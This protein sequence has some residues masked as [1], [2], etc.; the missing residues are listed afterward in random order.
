MIERVGGGRREE[1]REGD[2]QRNRGVKE[3][4]ERREESMER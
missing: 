1:R 4:S 3:R 2:G